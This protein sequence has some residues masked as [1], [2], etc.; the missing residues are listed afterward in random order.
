MR[1]NVDISAEVTSVFYSNGVTTRMNVKGLGRLLKRLGFKRAPRVGKGARWW[2]SRREVVRVFRN[3]Y[4]GGVTPE[5]NRNDTDDTLDNS[6]W[7]A[8]T[9]LSARRFPRVV[10][11][12]A[13]NL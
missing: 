7:I 6:Q 8:V 9:L 11:R 10:W 13:A 4:A 1:W 2:M 3:W 5:N 12:K